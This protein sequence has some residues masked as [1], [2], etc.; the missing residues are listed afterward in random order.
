MANI[1][2]KRKGLEDFIRLRS[3]LGQE[4]T[5]CLF[6]LTKAQIEKL[7]EG[8]I[9]IRRTESVQQLAELYSCADL[10]LNLTYE[11]NFSTTN[12]EALACGTPV[13]TYDTGGC[14]EMLDESCGRVVKCGDLEA[15]VREIGKLMADP[16][17]GEACVRKSRTFER[18][19]AFAGYVSL[20]R[21]ILEHN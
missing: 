18:R 1:W 11:D 7:Q 13:L 12:M 6:G 10:F 14:A 21:R 19:E 5:I 15:V 9:G 16:I 3:M 17:A 20:Y 2:E 4:Y 8:M